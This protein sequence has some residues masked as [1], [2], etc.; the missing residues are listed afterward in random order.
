MIKKDLDS[1]LTREQLHRFTLTCSKR[2]GS[3]C[4]VE[5]CD[6]CQGTNREPL[7]WG[8]LFEKPK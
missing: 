3:L 1:L 4:R 6:H 2:W 8:E 7:P 5:G